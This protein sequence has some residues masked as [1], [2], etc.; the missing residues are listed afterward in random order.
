RAPDDAPHWLGTD[1]VATF[2]QARIETA[3]GELQGDG[4][5]PLTATLWLPPDLDYRERGE[6]SDKNLAL[7]LDYRYNAVPL[8][9]GSTL[10]VYVNGA[11]VSSTPMPH[12]ER[13][14]EVL[15]TVVPVP[16]VALRPGENEFTFRF[17]FRSAQNG[18][19][20]NSKP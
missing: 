10:Q 8:G 14:S 13:A 15:E 6:A 19:I 17:A 5:Q 9:E 11:Y 4:S 12:T 7:H 18:P 2:A 20:N 16:V 3:S 1:R